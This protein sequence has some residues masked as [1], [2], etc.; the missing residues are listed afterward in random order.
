LNHSE[1]F[2]L[3]SFFD[4]F[5]E[6]PIPIKWITIPRIRDTI[7]SP[8]IVQAMKNAN[9]DGTVIIAPIIEPLRKIPDIGEDLLLTTSIILSSLIKIKFDALSF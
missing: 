8:V 9:S 7:L 6:N 3:N 5:N 2:T 4:I 1:D